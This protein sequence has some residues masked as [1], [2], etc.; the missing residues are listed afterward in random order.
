MV[1]VLQTYHNI[2][3]DST[4]TVSQLDLNHSH[5]NHHLM[6][7]DQIIQDKKLK[8]NCDSLA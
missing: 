7:P 5:V 3:P 6:T 8:Y 4:I 2:L 1:Q